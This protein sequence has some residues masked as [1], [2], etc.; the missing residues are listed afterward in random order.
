MVI[1]LSASGIL[2][3]AKHDSVDSDRADPRAAEGARSRERKSEEVISEGGG[4]A[5]FRC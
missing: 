4:T 5:F 3:V 2:S 1:N